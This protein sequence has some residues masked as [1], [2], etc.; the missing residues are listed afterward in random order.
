LVA[1]RGRGLA[2]DPAKEVGRQLHAIESVSHGP[3]K[4]AKLEPP[5]TEQLPFVRQGRKQCA[6]GLARLVSLRI[7][8]CSD[9]REG[10]LYSVFLVQGSS[11]ISGA[12][13]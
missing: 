11:T 13:A 5:V 9:V 7:G 12:K 4:A 2:D 8:T 6:G 10:V 3:V 1:E